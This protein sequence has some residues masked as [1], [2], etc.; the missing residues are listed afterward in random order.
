[1]GWDVVNMTQHP[2]VALCR[3]LGM[4]YAG[5]CLVTDYDSGVEGRDDIAPVTMDEVFRV[6]EENAELTR[7][8]LHRA[9]PL[10]PSAD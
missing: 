1:M 7:R 5:V 8:I 4:A 6:L 2:E 9:I 3:V 10:L